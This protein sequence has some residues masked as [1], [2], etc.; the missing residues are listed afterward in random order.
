MTV[1]RIIPCV[2]TP[3]P[4]TVGDRCSFGMPVLT[5]YGID[6][7]KQYW[8]VKCPVCGRGGVGIEENS[9]YKAL[10]HWNNLMVRCYGIENK[11]IKY[12]D[13]FRKYFDP[14]TGC[15][16]EEFKSKWDEL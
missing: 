1:Y 7:H 12:E 8:T 9:S 16:Y 4:P 15:K 11:E 5:A 14:I 3:H 6:P 2:C 10:R 13:D